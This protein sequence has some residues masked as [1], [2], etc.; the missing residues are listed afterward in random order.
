MVVTKITTKRPYRRVTFTVSFT[1]PPNAE[2]ADCKAF[3]IDALTTRQ[4]RGPMW[5]ID[6]DTIV[7]RQYNRRSK[8]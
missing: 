4:G 2:V 8:E 1:I 3:V 6:H 5:A 7:V